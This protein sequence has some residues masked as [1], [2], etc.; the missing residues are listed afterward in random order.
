M[1]HK[2]LEN[3]SHTLDIYGGEQTLWD[4]A[5]TEENSRQAITDK[6]L[7]YWGLYKTRPIKEQVDDEWKARLNDGKTFEV[8]ETVSSYLMNALFFSDSFLSLIANEPGVDEPGNQIT[9][10]ATKY[11]LDM[12]NKS[13]FKREIKLFLSQ[14]LL[15]GFSGIMPYWNDD[16]KLCFHTI[17]GYDLF[18]DSSKRYD[19]L[20]SYSFRRFQLNKLEFAE[21]V[22]AGYLDIEEFESLEDAWNILKDQDSSRS[23]DLYLNRDTIQKTVNDELVVVYEFYEPIE[24]CLTRFVQ[25][26]ILYKEEGATCPWIIGCLFETPEDPYSLGLIESS[27]GIIYANNFFQNK[28]LDSLAVSV[29]NMWLFVDDGVTD[30]REIKSEPGKIITVGR[31]DSITPL[32]PPTNNF[33]LSYQ[34]QLNLEQKIEKNTG[35]GA[36]ISANNFRK[37]ERVTASEIEAVK[38]AGGNRLTTLFNMIEQTSILPV[39]YKALSIVAENM[40]GKATVALPSE[41]QGVVD[42]F[43]VLPEDLAHDYR[44]TVLATQSVINRDKN[45]SLLTEF[46]GLVSQVPQFQELVNYENLYYDLLIK[47]G[48][49]DPSRYIRQSEPE[50]E[51]EQPTSPAQDLLAQGNQAGGLPMEQAMQEQMQLG[52]T[53]KMFGEIAGNTEEDLA[54][55]SPE[56]NQIASN[57]L[58]T[59]I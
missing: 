34:E 49:D 54:G 28:R 20:T 6:W 46:I 38:D 30:P 57:V 25:E 11:F 3:T 55:M 50:Q 4:I 21:W 1:K 18:V 31:P 51:P 33:S 41:V 39:L 9:P 42:F 29:D 2:E 53:T 47:F 24:K 16:A 45:I 17:N 22:E 52:N 59:P 8:V 48:F 12:L 13:N 35:T 44:I 10:L 37:G 23:S 56:Q 43:A 32:P 19:P 14:L 40:T 58:N 26:N 15:T 7:V 36:L 5:C 27:V